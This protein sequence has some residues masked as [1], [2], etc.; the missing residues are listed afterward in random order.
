M[1]V[2]ITDNVPPL[3]IDLHSIRLK[4]VGCTLPVKRLIDYLQFFSSL[5]SINDR[6]EIFCSMRDI[7]KQNPIFHIATSLNHIGYG[8]GVEQPLADSVTSQ[9]IR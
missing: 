9:L 8:E 1:L 3:V 6:L 2:Q 5:H 4:M 7:L